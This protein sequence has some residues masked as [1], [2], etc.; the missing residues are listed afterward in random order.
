MHLNSIY[1]TADLK[2]LTGISFSRDDNSVAGPKPAVTLR[3]TFRLLA[4]S[5]LTCFLLWA[6]PTVTPTRRLPS[7]VSST[8]PTD[9][10]SLII[11]DNLKV[12]LLS[13][14]NRFH[15]EDVTMD[16]MRTMF[17]DYCNTCSVNET[18]KKDMSHMAFMRN[19]AAERGSFF[20]EEYGSELCR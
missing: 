6:P 8:I 9:G 16:Q 12:A 20:D 14:L 18:V 7:Y 15:N 13:E 11:P 5:K 4:D 2:A 3:N 10:M 17:N 19:M 1:V